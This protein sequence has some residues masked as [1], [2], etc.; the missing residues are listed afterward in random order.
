MATRA[1]RSVARSSTRLPGL[2]AFLL[3][4]TRTFFYHGFL[5]KVNYII[6]SESQENRSKY[7]KAPNGKV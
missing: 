6:T 3:E 5:H 2:Q 1:A 7:S 4:I